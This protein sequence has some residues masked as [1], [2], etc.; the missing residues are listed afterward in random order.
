MTNAVEFLSS[1]LTGTRDAVGTVREAAYKS[2]SDVIL[3]AGSPFSVAAKAHEIL[4]IS[5]CAPS[6]EL[7][8]CI[9]NGCFD[10][11]LTTRTNAVMTLSSLLLYAITLCLEGSDEDTTKYAILEQLVDIA[12]EACLLMITSESN[13]DKLFPNAVHVLAVAAYAISV[14]RLHI[15]ATKAILLLKGTVHRTRVQSLASPHHPF[16][17]IMWLNVYEIILEDMNS[18]TLMTSALHKS[19]CYHLTPEDITKLTNKVIESSA[20][21]QY[22]IRQRLVLSSTQTFALSFYTLD[23][24]RTLVPALADDEQF[25]S[26]LHMS[27][28][29]LPLL[30]YH[31]AYETPLLAGK[32]AMARILNHLQSVSTPLAD[33]EITA[34]FEAILHKAIDPAHVKQIDTFLLMSLYIFLSVDKDKSSEFEAVTKGSLLQFVELDSNAMALTAWLKVFPSLHSC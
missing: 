10:T 16:V 31:G 26:I 15:N 33:N 9:R 25:T 6:T 18:Y 34:I 24:L 7:F 13:N 19:K 12:V 3:V 2:L 8:T 22:H 29:M 4:S 5:A 14:L 32:A 11:K 20:K 28:T 17:D 23:Q 21:T 30:V 1:L 27:T